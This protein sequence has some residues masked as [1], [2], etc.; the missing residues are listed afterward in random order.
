M[1]Q[2]SNQIIQLA[3]ELYTKRHGNDDY[4]FIH[5]DFKELDFIIADFGE[6]RRYGED[7]YFG[8]HG[9]PKGN[10]NLIGQ[11]L[12]QD[13]LGYNKRLARRCLIDAQEFFQFAES[14]EGETYQTPSNL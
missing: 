13:L 11:T 5:D 9:Y 6:W 14:T 10:T 3:A 1:I 7:K 2:H 8:L 12:Y 4:S